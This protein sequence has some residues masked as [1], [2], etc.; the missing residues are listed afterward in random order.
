[1]DRNRLE[2]RLRE[3]AE[4]VQRATEINPIDFREFSEFCEPVRDK[5][6]YKN[7]DPPADSSYLRK[8]I[9]H[10]L[11]I[12]IAAALVILAIVVGTFS[13]SA[14]FGSDFLSQVMNSSGMKSG[15][16]TGKWFYHKGNVIVV[17]VP[18]SPVEIFVSKDGGE[19]WSV[20]KVAGTDC[21]Y[22]YGRLIKGFQYSGGFV[23]MN[24]D[25]SGYLVLTAEETLGSQ[26]ARIFLTQNGGETWGEIKNLNDIHRFT[27]TGAGYSPEEI[28]FVSF[29]YYVDSGPDIW[30]SEDR[31]ENWQRLLVRMPKEYSEYR[32]DAQSPSF[33]GLKGTYTLAFYHEADGREEK[34]IVNLVSD[35]GGRTWEFEAKGDSAE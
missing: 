10:R 35:D 25:E 24:E 21:G 19:T 32:F 8:E 4:A 31:G 15:A 2:Q 17:V 18:E 27:V 9:H 3:H 1:M 22:H 13:V 7:A 16:E 5:A 11:R 14:L 20:S 23:G 33:D 29:R 12:I 30:Y 6:G 28:V 26:D 34:G